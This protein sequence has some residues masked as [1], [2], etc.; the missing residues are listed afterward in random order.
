MGQGG[1]INKVAVAILLVL[2]LVGGPILAVM[3]AILVSV[4]TALFYGDPPPPA[5][6][7]NE[8]M[9][10]CS[11]ETPR[12]GTWAAY[13]SAALILSATIVGAVGFSRLYKS[14]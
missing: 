1:R 12:W 9:F 11:R 5:E 7:S 14:E 8:T 10:S 6:C 3:S 4:L 13:G 2:T